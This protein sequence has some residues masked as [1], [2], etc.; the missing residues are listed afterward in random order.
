MDVL[1]SYRNAFTDESRRVSGREP[2]WLTR[3][4]E[5][6]FEVFASRGFPAMDEE[7]WRFTNVAPIASVAFPLAGTGN[8]EAR[9][10]LERQFLADWKRH[11]LVFVNGRISSELSSVGSLPEGVVVTSLAA[12]LESYGDLV[13]EVVSLG[14]LGEAAT[15]FTHLNQAL[16]SDGAFVRIPDGAAVAEPIHLVF[17]TTSGEPTMAHPRNVILAGKGSQSVVVESYSGRPDSV[18]L[19]NAS[20]NVLVREGAV[21]DHYHVQRESESAFHVASLGFVQARGATLS[22]HSIAL[23]AR[24][25]RNDIRALLDG[26]GSDLSLNGLYAVRHDQH[27]DHH[28]LID[29]KEPHCT[30]RELYKGILADRSSGVFD[31]RI[32][33]R[34]DAQKTNAQQSNKNLLLSDQALVN[35][36]PQLEI[37]A[38]DVKCAHGATIGQIDADAIFYLQTR[39]IGI[40]EAR[41]LLT[42]GFLADVSERIR[43]AALREVVSA[44]VFERAA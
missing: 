30:S 19:V 33:V 8:G 44:L 2:A 15:V 29:H 37:N 32:V 35:T 34:A 31:G 43:V 21:L 28:T 40:A 23:G 4:R 27:V 10:L 39:G 22:N 20:T 11:E 36:N 17:L 5:E 38:D 6:S 7:S 24:L 41:Q 14:S 16:F 25:A 12:A 3:A 42:R 9:P 1:G 26:E 13:E 18:Y